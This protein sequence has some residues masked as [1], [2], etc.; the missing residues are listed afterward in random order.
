M[1]S[2][3]KSDTGKVRDINEDFIYVNDEKVGSLPNLYIVSDGMGGHKAGEIASSLA[4][5]SF[6]DYVKNNTFAND[7]EI[8][9]FLVNAID[10]ANKM[11]YEKSI[12]DIKCNGMGATFSVCTFVNNKI[13]AAHVGDSR[14]YLINKQIHQLSIDHTYVNEMVRVGKITQRQA[15]HHPQKNI[16]TRAVG[17][18]EN[19]SRLNGLNPQIIKVLSFVILGLCVAVVGLIKTSRVSS[20]NYSVIAKDIEMDA[21]LAVALGGNA[22]G[23]GKFNMTASIIGAYVIQFLTQ[24][25]FKFNVKSTALPAYK[26]VV[27]I[28]LVVIS[29][30]VVREWFTATMK[31]LK[32]KEAA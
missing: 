13:Y 27:V 23:G 19:S 31:K 2:F 15:K 29:A 6:L 20:I 32:T 1:I 21:I 11:V 25:L 22:L 7:D 8:L 28:V 16:I 30:P 9:D 17:I 3:G 10:Y 24:T 12:S 4:V 18:N 14:I 26:A 5:N